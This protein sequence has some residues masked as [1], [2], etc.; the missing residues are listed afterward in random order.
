MQSPEARWALPLMAIT[1]CSWASPTF[2]LPPAW[3]QQGLTV[4]SLVFQVQC[5]KEFISIR[6]IF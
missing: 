4:R 3:G 1:Q 2:P 5:P 6:C